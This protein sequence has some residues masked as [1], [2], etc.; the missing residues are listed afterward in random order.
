MAESTATPGETGNT[1]ASGISRMTLRGVQ[2]SVFDA[3]MLEEMQLTG[4]PVEARTC[5][6][7][8]SPMVA[9]G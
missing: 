2:L 1:M 8:I 5:R 9:S 7:Q 6:K 3:V 4:N